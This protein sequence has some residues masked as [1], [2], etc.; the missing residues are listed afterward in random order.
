M[1]KNN[2][3][4]RLLHRAARV[5][6]LHQGGATLSKAWFLS[7]FGLP[8]LRMLDLTTTAVRLVDAPAADLTDPQH[9]FILAGLDFIHRLKT[10]DPGI[11]FS[12]VEP[13]VLAVEFKGI[14]MHCRTTEELYFIVEIFIEGIYDMVGTSQAV[15]ID[16]GANVGTAALYFAALPQVVKIHAYEIFPQ[17][18]QLARENLEQNPHLACKIQLTALGL[19]SHRGVH[20]LDYNPIVKGHAGLFGILGNSSE[21]L[22]YSKQTVEVIDAAEAIAIARSEHPRH[23]LIV[24]L[25]CEG[26]EYSILERLRNSGSIRDIDAFVIEWHQK[27]AGLLKEI[28]YNEGY[29]VFSSDSPAGTHGMVYAFRWA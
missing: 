15:I 18:A 12:W 6:Q 28:L 11:M 4:P 2:R 10:W 20:E 27:G 22:E 16:V 25:D 19:A 14:R 5:A 1:T 29:G 24:K 7:G 9:H 17:T 26:A 8:P 23:R 13:G 21:R 3:L